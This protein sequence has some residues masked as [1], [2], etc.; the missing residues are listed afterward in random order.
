[1]SIRTDFYTIKDSFIPGAG[2]SVFHAEHY[3]N[4]D[5]SNPRDCVLKIS[6][7]NIYTKRLKKFSPHDHIATIFETFTLK[8]GS[9]DFDCTI[10]EKGSHDMLVLISESY[11]PILRNNTS[12]IQNLIFQQIS[13]VAALAQR[14]FHRSDRKPENAVFCDGFVKQ[15]DFAIPGST[16][17][18]SSPDCA[19]SMRQPEPELARRLQDA[20]ACALTCL[21]FASGQLHWHCDLSS[22]HCADWQ[23]TRCIEIKSNFDRDPVKRVDEMLSWWSEAKSFFAWCLHPEWEKR[24]TVEMML[25]HAFVQAGNK[26]SIREE[27]REAVC[28]LNSLVPLCALQCAE[29]SHASLVLSLCAVA[30]LLEDRPRPQVARIATARQV[31][32]RRR[33]HCC[34]ED[35][36][37]PDP[38][39][40]PVPVR[41]A[42]RCRRRAFSRGAGRRQAQ[43]AT[44]RRR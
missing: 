39:R 29:V 20:W 25:Q 21:I 13:G 42:L 9:A 18:Y 43:A 12:F 15:I 26:D 5:D 16:F 23:C 14:G 36:A 33:R 44:V 27:L 6:P 17:F 37:R 8:S 32:V 10:M 41:R 4:E 3:R 30:D 40:R 34:R 1:M 24:P 31:R 11:A 19:V 22:S 38:Q 2:G 35:G 7:L 28:F